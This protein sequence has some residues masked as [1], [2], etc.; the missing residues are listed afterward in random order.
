VQRP[1]SLI[2]AVVLLAGAHVFGIAQL[3]SAIRNGLLDIAPA[4]PSAITAAVYA[5]LLG[6]LALLWLGRHWARFV[7]AVAAFL[8]LLIN[9]LHLPS[10][11]AAATAWFFGKAVAL[12]L[13]YVPAS[14]RWFRAVGPNNSS[15]PTPL[16]G[17]A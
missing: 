12:T 15:K 4:L 7:C 13:L 17:A 1:K 10:L 5:L 3:V 14:N 11:S 16:R 6:L 9:A 8:A 2:V